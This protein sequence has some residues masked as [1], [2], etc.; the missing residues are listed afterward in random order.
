MAL[1]EQDPALPH[2][3]LRRELCKPM[4]G[5]KRPYFLYLLLYL[6]IFLEEPVA[7]ELASPMCCPHPRERVSECFTQGE[8][9]MASLPCLVWIALQ[10]QGQS[11]IAKTRHTSVL[12]GS[13]HLGTV[14]LR[15]VYGNPLLKDRPRCSQIPKEPEDL[16][17]CTAGA[18]EQYGLWLMLSD[19]EKLSC[20]FLSPPECPSHFVEHEQSYQYLEALRC[21]P[22]LRAQL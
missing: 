14:S 20:Q 10:P 17:S 7:V 8:C 11:R 3:C 22:C 15:V 5:F 2:S 1:G 4:F 21:V 6:L 9:L 19:D 16:P 13:Q 18:Q 12:P